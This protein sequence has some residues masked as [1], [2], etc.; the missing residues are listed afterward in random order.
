MPLGLGQPKEK[1][2]AILRRD[3]RLPMEVEV[4]IN[5]HAVLPGT[6]ATFTENVSARGARV[7]STRRWKT[8]EQLVISMHA[9]AFRCL[10]RV[11]YCEPVARAGYAVGLE[12]TEASGTW[13]VNGGAK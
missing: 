13:V 7:L 9:G 1:N 11:A 6:E 4:Q 2:Y 5:G 12:F 8:N 10:A 3:A